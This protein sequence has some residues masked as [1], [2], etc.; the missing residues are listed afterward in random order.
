MEIQITNKN[1]QLGRGAYS[2]VFAGTY[3]GKNVAVKRILLPVAVDDN[4]VKVMQQIL[5]HPNVV[6]LLHVEND[7]DFRSV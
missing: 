6:K 7:E 5:D 3:K 2:I 4:E 1:D